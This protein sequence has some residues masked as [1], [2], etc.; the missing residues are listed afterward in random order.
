MEE[1]AGLRSP[2]RSHWRRPQSVEVAE[3]EVLV[4]LPQVAQGSA[5]RQAVGLPLAG[6]EEVQKA[7]ALRSVEAP[8]LGG[9]DR[10]ASALPEMARTAKSVVRHT[11]WA[12][13]VAAEA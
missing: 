3:L 12:Q 11:G 4:R 13:L 2:V 6:H 8:R 7:E 9:V 1:E 5:Q 10:K